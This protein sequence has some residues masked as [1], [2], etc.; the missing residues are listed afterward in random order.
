MLPK[1]LLIV[2]TNTRYSQ[3]TDSFL[4]K[5]YERNFTVRVKTTIKDEIKAKVNLRRQQRKIAH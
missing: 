1:L 4:K 2:I 5:I 3:R